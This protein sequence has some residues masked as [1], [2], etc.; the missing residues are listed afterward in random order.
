M[1]TVSITYFP[2]G[3]FAVG[4][5]YNVQWSALVQR[6]AQRR[7]VRRKGDAPGF[8][9]ATFNP[10]RRKVE[11]V[12]RVHAVGLDLDHGVPEWK[13]LVANF[14]AVACFVHTTWRSQPDAIRARAFL[15]L[16]RP[17]T[18]DEYYRV[19]T[20]CRDV[21]T[22]GG[23][24][25]DGQ[26]KDPSRFWYL[27]AC[28][29]GAAF[30]WAE[31]CGEPIDVEGALAVVPPPA[32]PAA[33][34]FPVLPPDAGGSYMHDRLRLIERAQRYVDRC[35]PAISGQGGHRITFVLAQ[36]LVRGFGLDE[37]AAYSLLADWNRRCQPPWSEW[38]LRRK[39]RQAIE[40]GTLPPGSLRD[41]QRPR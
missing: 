8:S 31:G 39:I 7:E 35:E 18:A 21:V 32:P 26:A 38:A 23:L 2:P 4:T 19:W 9:L 24:E 36:K 14:Q 5:R 15:C 25:V 41:A 27:P 11:N 33:P 17:V 37:A 20:F 13:T 34:P 12:E 1:S 22:K 16:S 30:Q 29:P 6:L 28:A 40:R 10:N 3:E